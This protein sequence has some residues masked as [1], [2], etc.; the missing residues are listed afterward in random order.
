M[1][2]YTAERVTLAGQEGGA[3]GGRERRLR[4]VAINAAALKQAR[5]DAGLSLAELAGDSMSRQAVH[6]FETGRARPTLAKLRLIVERLGN[7]SVEAV[8]ADASEDR[9]AE[10]DQRQAFDELGE[11]AAQFLH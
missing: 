11:L 3:H 8:L 1:P 2:C 5:L 10:L 7:T 4:G 6:L 9:L